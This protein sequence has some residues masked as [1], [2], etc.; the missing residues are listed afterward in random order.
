MEP[1]TFVGLPLCS[2]AN[3]S[4]ITE[5]VKVLREIGIVQE[6]GKNASTLKDHGD[7]RLSEIRSDFG[8]KNLLNFPQ[9]LQDS[10]RIRSVVSEWDGEGLLFALGGECSICVGSLAGLKGNIGDKIGIV[11]I[12]AHGDFNTPETTPSGY[13]GGMCLAFA[14]GRGPSLKGIVDE[15]KPILGEENVVHIGGRA[16][17]PLESE[18]MS[19]SPMKTYSALTLRKNGVPSSL[20]L[21]ISSLA[22]RCDCLACHLD[23]DCIDPELMPAVNFP[24]QSGLSLEETKAIVKL[25]QRTGKLKLFDLAGYNPALDPNRTCALK[26]TRFT[27][28]TFAQQH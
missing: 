24:A 9:F 7:A 14:C 4:G 25:I 5:A 6:L 3:V 11:W 13:I 16:L 19:S 12:D 26:L 20:N 8:P 10:G 27:S 18:N 2:R 22:D 28:E 21:A 23:V 15:R 17:D 1:I